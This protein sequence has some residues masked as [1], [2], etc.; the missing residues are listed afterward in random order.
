MKAESLLKDI[1]SSLIPLNDKI[2]NHPYIIEAEKG[3]LP[4]DKIKAFA[5][6]Q[7]YIISHDAKSLS[8][9]LSRATSLD[10]IKLFRKLAE[11]DL[12]G[13]HC[14]IK[15]AEELGF[16]IQD[17]ENYDPI[18]DAVAYTH[19]LCALAQFTSPG[20]QI[21]A[22]TANL[23]VWGLNCGRLSEA[24][25][26]KYNIKETS[27]LDL[28]AGSTDELEREALQIIERYLPEKENAMRRVVRLIQAYELMFWDGLYKS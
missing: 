19:Y 7:Y 5:A 9:M 20:E 28:F 3:I 6:N 25:R 8:L 26:V 18:P 4:M 13:L 22:L 24:L 11:G 10:E 15:M 16:T 17:L 21:M 12:E 27:F 2:L 1:R 23:P 14:I